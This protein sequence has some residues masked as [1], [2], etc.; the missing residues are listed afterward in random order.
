MIKGKFG[1]DRL[2]KVGKEASLA[3]ITNRISLLGAQG[4]TILIRRYDARD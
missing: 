1:D 3:K 4:Y 2:I